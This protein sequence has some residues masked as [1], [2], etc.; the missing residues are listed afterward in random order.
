LWLFYGILVACAVILLAY[1]LM[2]H[3]AWATFPAEWNLGLAKPLDSFKSWVLSSRV[4][5]TPHPIFRFFFGPLSATI[6]FVIRGFENILLFLPWVVIVSGFALL[7]NHYGGLRL[8]LL[9]IF[10][11]LFM[12]W[13]GLWD[14][15]MET[16]ALMLAAVT[17]ALLIGIP[18]GIW[19]SRNPRAEKLLQP[20]LDTM[21]TMPAF[22]Y[23]I[24]VVLFFGIARV[25]AVIA[26][27]IYAIP[28]AVRLTHLGLKR[29]SADVRE[30]ADSFGAT[31]RQ[32]LLSV[33]IPQ[34]MPTIMAG[35]NQS[36]MMALSMVVI[37][38][39]VG[40][41]GLGE[42][43]LQSLRRLNVGRAFE[44]G[45][46]IVFLAVL[47]DRLSYAF[48]QIDYRSV[49]TY[50]GFRLLPP[51]LGKEPWALAIERVIDGVYRFFGWISRQLIQQASK[52][53]P[54]R[55]WLEKNA[56]LFTSGIFLLLLMGIA[57]A[58][59]WTEF[60]TS[61][62]IPL[63]APVTAAVNWAKVNLYEFAQLGSFKFGTGPFSDFLVVYVLK[64]LR[65]FL[66][67]EPQSTPWLPWSVF[68]LLL[69]A[70]ALR[71]ADWRL[72][73]GT[74][75]GM[76]LIGLLGMWT[77]ALDTFTQVVV[78]VLLS[79]MIGVPLGVWSGRNQA[80]ENFLRPINDFLQT[81]PSFV[82]LV[83]VIML[84]SIGRVPGILAS[85]LYALPP[86]IRLTALGVRQVDPPALESSKS[87]G[88]T[89]WQTLRMVQIPLAMPS[90]LLGINQTIMMV[91]AMVIIAG[92]VGAQGV[93]T[94]VVDGMSNN[95]LGQSAEAGIAI[96]ILAMILDRITQGW[97]HQQEKAARG[98]K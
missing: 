35:V 80:V 69:S 36:I 59:G 49:K 88:A 65:L 64:P 5:E 74:L 44:G 38:A 16:L 47:L 24:P 68:A 53:S 75:I 94:A 60:P 27:I 71:V 57:F 76:V 21:Q 10:C 82:F 90:I 7:G 31:A 52:I 58:V 11:L 84:F 39:L 33:E 19:T 6:D 55:V 92:L 12:G 66:G 85:V 97:A 4:G 79:V 46:A 54:L 32:K 29:V 91:L 63:S 86:T 14:E 25:P 56:N 8:M 22:V 34:A 26:T 81:I 9:S 89:T 87:F 37:A 95:K 2:N 15:S 78:A 1:H 62:R 43:V 20:V 73:V 17:L 98:E 48:S 83:P 23:L 96:V 40:S 18:L 51:N 41:G 93:G 42:V 72:A 28:P 77:P 45:M 61:W 70:I 3:S 67:G 13:M 50:Q 30:A